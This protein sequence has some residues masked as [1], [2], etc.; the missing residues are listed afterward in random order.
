MSLGI[1]LIGLPRSF[2]TVLERYFI[3]R[4]DFEIY[5]EHVTQHIFSMH[6]PALIKSLYPAE[7][8]SDDILSALFKQNTAEKFLIRE[9]AWAIKDAKF[10]DALP[11][12]IQVVMVIRKPEQA[13]LSHE[14][15][16]QINKDAEKAQNAD[17]TSFHA[18]ETVM[19]YRILQEI[20]Q[21]LTK[22]G[23]KPVLINDVNLANNPHEVVENLC[24]TLGIS[25]NPE[26]L[27]WT[28]GESKFWPYTT[29]TWQKEVTESTRFEPLLF[30]NKYKF[31]DPE[32]RLTSERAKDLKVLIEANNNI[33]VQMKVRSKM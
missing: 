21:R 3:G 17:F 33:Y 24:R 11:A 2:I 10:L 23:K 27:H 32:L 12:D 15:Y 9:Q 20:Q 1:L 19:D 5:H 18:A 4:N 6:N 7:S 22:Q 30:R 16:Y 28:A 8:T 26:H 25:F 13:V 29:E 14:K 31:S